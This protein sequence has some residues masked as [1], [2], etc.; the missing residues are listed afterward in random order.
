[1]NGREPQVSV[2][3]RSYDASRVEAVRAEAGLKSAREETRRQSAGRT[4]FDHPETRAAWKRLRRRVRGSLTLWTVLWLG[5]FVALSVLGAADR[6]GRPDKVT[7]P[8][9]GITFLVYLCFLYLRV[10]SLR[11][12]GRMR[13]DLETYEWQPVPAARRNPHFKDVDG[14]AVQ[15]RLD[16]AEGEPAGAGSLRKTAPRK[17]GPAEGAAPG[18]LFGGAG[19][20]WTGL[21]SARNPAHRRRWT[22]EMADGAWYAG[23]PL[24]A[25]P[26]DLVGSGVVST[27]GGGD[28]FALTSTDLTARPARR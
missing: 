9:G 1:M 21:L 16:D 23:D 18:R 17:T 25:H 24:A 3:G 26:K 19:E 14:V 7:G 5:S 2:G 27:P 12:L 11:C 20:R 8:Y 10:G 6:L 28:L 22:E 15:L 13:R 4:A